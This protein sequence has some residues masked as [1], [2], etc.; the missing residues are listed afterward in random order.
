MAAGAGPALRKASAV[1]TLPLKQTVNQSGNLPLPFRIRVSG[2]RASKLRRFPRRQRILPLPLDPLQKS[3]REVARKRL[4]IADDQVLILSIG[5]GVKFRPDGDRN[6]YRTAVKILAQNPK[7]HLYVVGVSPSDAEPFLPP[8]SRASE[9]CHFVGPLPDA[10]CYQA[11]AD[12]YIEGFPF[13]SNTA[14]LE[15]AILAIPAVGAYSPVSELLVANDDAIADVLISPKTEQDYVAN[16]SAFA[17][18]STERARAGTILRERLVETHAG[19]GWLSRLAEMYEELASLAHVP[20]RIEASD[21]HSTT[22]DNALATWCKATA[23]PR[24]QRSGRSI[25]EAL[26]G[27]MC[28]L[29]YELRKQGY[30]RNAIWLLWRALDSGANRLPLLKAMA[31]ASVHWVFKKV[32]G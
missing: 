30:H 4:G 21:S 5:R 7:A 19:A 20:G 22:T 2:C 18:N 17:G 27:I 9:R 25:D 1:S 29:A 11:A 14:L 28:A 16:A 12:V 6:F 32:A 26:T 15:T 3:S 31:K 24:T 23:D 13:G 10:S 8:T